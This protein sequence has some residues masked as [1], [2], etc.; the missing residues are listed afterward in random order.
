[1][2]L[3]TVGI[4]SHDILLHENISNVVVVASKKDFIVFLNKYLDFINQFK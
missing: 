2:S 4:N 1:M 3:Y